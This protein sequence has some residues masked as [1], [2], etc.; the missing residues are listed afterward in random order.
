MSATCVTTS[1]ANG[2][3][4][5]VLKISGVQPYSTAH[6]MVEFR[7]SPTVVARTAHELS[8]ATKRRQ[9]APVA[10]VLPANDHLRPMLERTM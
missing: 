8:T 3:E 9:N 10:N 2:N 6:M 5:S 7:L 1:A 4:P